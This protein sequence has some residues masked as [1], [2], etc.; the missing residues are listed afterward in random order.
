MYQ[1]YFEKLNV[2]NN[3][4]AL[5]L[6]IYK[7]LKHYPKDEK[8][9]L[10]DQIKRAATSVPTNLAEGSSRST[11]KDQAKFTTIS[12]GSLMELWNLLILSNDLEFITE[13]ELFQFKREIHVIAKQLNGL[14]NAQLKHKP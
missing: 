3:A 6:N 7:V 13:K 10:V 14:R 1:F 8:Y 9:N 2:W 4:R 11:S 12:H 5:L